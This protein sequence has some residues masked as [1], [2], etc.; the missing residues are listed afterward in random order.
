MPSFTWWRRGLRHALAGLLCALCWQT[1]SAQAPDYPARALRIIVPY[2][3]GGF[4][5]QF[6]RLLAQHLHQAWGQAAV[7]E[8][9]PGGGT[10]IGTDLAAR[11]PA[12]GHTLLVAS[13][14]F[15]VNQSLYARVP[16]D[17]LRDFTPVVLA[18]QC[19]NVLV[20]R[21]GLAAG[22]LAELLDAA[23]KS[24]GTINYASGGNGSSTHLAME[25]L[26]NM[27]R[28]DFTHVPYKGSAPAITDLLAGQVDVLFDNLP[29]VLPYLRAGKLRALAVSTAR[30]SGTLPDVPTTAEGGV[31]GFDVQVWFGV[32]VRSGTPQAIVDKLNAEI[33]RMLAKPDT[34][35]RFA[36]QGVDTAGGSS[37]AFA[38]YLADQS[39]M[40][41]RVIQAV[42]IRPE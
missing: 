2:P 19:P 15:A 31:A 34:K 39:Q 11:A 38:R 36:A 41:R 6:A 32:V 17:P 14:A 24:P 28:V 22:T 37:A 27:A 3:V 18:A 13:F 30:R 16:F 29:N 23:R 9:R 1:V 35:A 25:L 4:N 12:D 20:A 10:V 21:K 40:W 8:N 7:V 42:G 26:K 5:D 33:N